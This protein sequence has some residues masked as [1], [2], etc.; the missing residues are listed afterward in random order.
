MH[1]F[2]KTSKIVTG[3]GFDL[4]GGTVSSSRC[5]KCAT[6]SLSCINISHHVVFIQ[7]YLLNFLAVEK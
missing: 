6:L 3:S 1:N 4:A 7:C 2:E 5:S